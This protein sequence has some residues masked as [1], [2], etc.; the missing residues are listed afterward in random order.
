LFEQ[1]LEDKY[2][3]HPL[4]PKDLKMK[5]LNLQVMSRYFISSDRHSLNM[6]IQALFSICPFFSV[7]FYT[8][9]CFSFEGV[10]IIVVIQHIYLSFLRIAHIFICI[11]ISVY[12]LLAYWFLPIANIV[13]SSIQPLQAQGYAIIVGITSS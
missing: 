5:A 10:N 9:T 12:L 3:K 6:G 1:Y 7:T 8:S 13:C 11:F 4:L 2:P